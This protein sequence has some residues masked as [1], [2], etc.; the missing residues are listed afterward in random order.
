MLL[1]VWRQV[2]ILNPTNIFS[3]LAFIFPKISKGF[4]NQGLLKNIYCLG[5]EIIRPKNIKF[6]YNVATV[7]WIKFE[8]LK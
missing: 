1:K 8:V 2:Y 4:A 7:T 5:P 3:F 6:C